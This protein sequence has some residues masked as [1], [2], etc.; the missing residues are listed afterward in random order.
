MG[1]NQLPSLIADYDEMKLE[2]WAARPIRRN[3]RIV[4]MARWTWRTIRNVLI[5]MFG[6]STVMAIVLAVQEPEM[7]FEYQ[8]TIAYYGLLT[9]MAVLMRSDAPEWFVAFYRKW[10]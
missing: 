7:F 3:S 2:E 5:A 6:I 10:Y 1:K 8:G 9:A 4:Q